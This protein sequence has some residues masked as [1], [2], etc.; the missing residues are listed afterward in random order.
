MIPNAQ[1]L[2]HLFIWAWM[3]AN[4]HASFDRYCAAVR[5]ATAL[6]MRAPER[7]P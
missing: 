7:T 3:R 1:A 5:R 6:L 4:P 2:F